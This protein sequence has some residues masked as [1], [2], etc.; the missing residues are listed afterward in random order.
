MQ[1]KVTV[2]GDDGYEEK[3]LSAKTVIL[4]ELLRTLVVKIEFLKEHELEEFVEF[5][6]R[7]GDQKTL[8]WIKYIHTEDPF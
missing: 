3:V 5:A 2:I 8:E 4:D 6:A 1:A 7:L